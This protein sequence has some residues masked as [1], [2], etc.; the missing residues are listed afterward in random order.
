MRGI[1]QREDVNPV[2]VCFILAALITIMSFPTL[3]AASQLWRI[4]PS[5][6][7][8]V[9]EQKP[10]SETYRPSLNPSEYVRVMWGPGSHP[11]SL[12]VETA[13]SSASLTD[14]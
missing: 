1:D 11:D 10:E 14:R 2:A 9:M 7:L 6:A 3:L 5:C 13:H 12:E 8:P 4:A